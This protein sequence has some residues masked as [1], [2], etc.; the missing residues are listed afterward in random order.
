LLRR[1]QELS[2][3]AWSDLLN[4]ESRTVARSLVLLLQEGTRDAYLRHQP[5]SQA[6][7]PRLAYDFGELQVFVPQKARVRARLKSPG[8]LAL[9]LLRLADIRKWPKLLSQL[10]RCTL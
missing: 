4:F 8:G 6:P 7:T 2:D 10:R 1:G 9:S 3:R 5:L